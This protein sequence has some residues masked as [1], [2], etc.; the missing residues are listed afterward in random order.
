MPKIIFASSTGRPYAVD[1]ETGAVVPLDVLC[2][3]CGQC[4]DE[5]SSHTCEEPL[6]GRA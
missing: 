2:E 3:D 1:Q 6:N 4:F 5:G